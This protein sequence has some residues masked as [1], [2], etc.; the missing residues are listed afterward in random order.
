MCVAQLHGLTHEDIAQ[1][2]DC[3]LSCVA[4]AIAW[5]KHAGL[6]N[7]AGEHNLQVHIAEHQR[8]IGELE[9]QWRIAKKVS[10]RIRDDGKRVRVPMAHERIAVLS[11]ELRQWREMLMKLEGVYEQIVNVKVSGTVEHKHEVDLTKLNNIELT[12]LEEIT[13]KARNGHGPN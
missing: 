8:M 6:F 12:Q 9:R 7:M 2:Y 4:Q 5:G 10:V 3:S 11:R 1:K 13:A